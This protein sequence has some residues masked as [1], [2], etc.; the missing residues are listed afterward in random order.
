MIRAG[1][2]SLVLV[3]C[4][5]GLPVAQSGEASIPEQIPL[6]S[7]W[8]DYNDR[9]AANLSRL[10]PPVEPVRFDI[11]RSGG[12]G[13]LEWLPAFGFSNEV[14]LEVPLVILENAPLSAL[15]EM[16]DG[17][18]QPLDKAL[19]GWIRDGGQLLIVG[20]SP[21]LESYAGSTLETLMGFA[22]TKD[23]N[24]FRRRKSRTIRGGGIRDVHVD[25]LHEGGLR[26]ASVLLTADADPFLIEN[27]VGRGRVTTLLS[28]AQGLRRRDGGEDASEWFASPAWAEVLH[29]V[30]EQ[31]TGR[32][33][34]LG[35]LPPRPAALAPA[36]ADAFDIRYF[37]IG[38]Q[39]YPY[40]YAA[41]EAFSRALAL[42]KVGFTSTVFAVNPR[43]P[44]DDRN[45]LR[46]IADAGLQIVYYDAIRRE[47]SVVRFPDGNSRPKRAR[48]LK[49]ED[50][51][52]D[53][54][55][56]R[57]RNSPARMLDGREYVRE[58]P[59]RAVQLIEEFKDGSM[60]GPAV[61]AMLLKQGIRPTVAPG[62]SQWIAA[63]AIRADAT[64]LTFQSFRE[65]GQ[66]LFPGLAQSTYLPGSYWTRP[67]DYGFRFT[68]LADAVDEL[69][70]PGYGYNYTARHAGPSS[71]RKSATEG[72][73]AL[74]DSNSTMRHMAVYAMGRPLQRR[75]LDTPNLS[76]WMETAWIAL[77]HGATGLAYW[78]LPRGSYAAE[79][80][81]FHLEIDRLG[82]WLR[83]LPREPAPIALLE[84]WTSR[85]EAG[86]PKVAKRMAGCLT[87]TFDALERGFEDVDLIFEERVDRVPEATR[88]IAIMAS[89]SLSED[90]AE[91]LVDFLRAGGHLFVES[92]SAV[93]TQPGAKALDLAQRS[94]KAAQIHA[95]PLAA[96]CEVSQF[97]DRFASRAWRAALDELEIQPR[98]ATADP[99]TK[100]AIRGNSELIHLYLLNPSESARS[101]SIEL[102]RR[103]AEREW[104]E[105]RSGKTVTVENG[106]TLRT[107]TPV[108]PGEA[109]IWASAA[110][111]LERL[112]MAI[113]NRSGKFQLDL[114]GVDSAGRPVAQ[115][116][117]LRV[118][119]K[120]RCAAQIEISTT[121][122]AGRASLPVTD[123]PDGLEPKIDWSAADPL[124]GRSFRPHVNQANLAVR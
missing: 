13:S 116:Y 40:S 58:L 104:V 6:I 25:F 42:R 94:G 91:S 122:V 10:S 53:I 24:R 111:R 18:G 7:P 98:A 118:S 90:A 2:L 108:N 105:L 3:F 103:W 110:R 57:F 74:R 93:R 92:G 106:R 72:W 120:T 21:S 41:G 76:T 52:W 50:I 5:G 88:V 33:H 49:G 73:V 34:V 114:S 60:V 26:G 12:Q 19:L 84:S 55:D 48:N 70:G 75:G 64:A 65:K 15:R 77:A 16:R 29:R 100:A 43:R 37:L 115:G 14:S 79:L 9:I 32:K 109:V 89:P 4:L 112:D 44:K 61:E 45:A 99:D 117:P 23:V 101:L 35:Q 81:T 30:V 123:C 80:E 63:A 47:S 97:S 22:P 66:Q 46:E 17:R 38:H 56:P 71:V 36:R 95:V 78:A 28:G 85:S 39:P 124:S 113:R 27:R 119:I 59:L 51:G 69:I 87:R 11:E 83:A 62:E 82:P 102:D 8:M 54:H 1:C 121:L 86:D 96:R 67:L 107:E 68:A 31:S 20:G